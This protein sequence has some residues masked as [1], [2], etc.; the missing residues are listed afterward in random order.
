MVAMHGSAETGTAETQDGIVSHLQDLVLETSDAEEF[1]R[2]LA[3]FSAALLAP[4]GEELWCNVLVV[5]RK[6]P[7]IIASSTACARV[8][9]QLQVAFGDGPCLTA[10]RS[11]TIIHVQDVFSDQRWPEY[12]SAVAS[13]GIGS[14]LGIPLPLEGD[15]SA[16]LN[17]YSSRSHGFSSDDIARAELFAE[18]SAKTLRLELRLVRLQHAKDDLESAMKSRTVIDMAVGIIMAQNRCSQ[19]TAMS[20]LLRASSSRNKKLRDVAVAVVE[21]ISTREVVTYFDE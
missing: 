15:S 19:E 12:M 3:V 2:E 10:M 1:F 17:I 16:A 20:V 6:R 4:P 13:H 5:Q 8:M 21:S 18:Q 7:V 14:I 11:G 9:D